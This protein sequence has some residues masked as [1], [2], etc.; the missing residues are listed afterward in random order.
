LVDVC[1][2]SPQTF[3][4]LHV[5]ETVCFKIPALGYGMITTTFIGNNEVEADFKFDIKTP[6]TYPTTLTVIIGQQITFSQHIPALKTG[7]FVQ[8]SKAR[9]NKQ[10]RDEL[11]DMTLVIDTR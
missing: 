10:I 6:S 5:D 4:G 3:N 11:G 8:K 2:G 1:R 9:I 7:F